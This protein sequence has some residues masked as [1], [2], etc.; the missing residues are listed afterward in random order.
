MKISYFIKEKKGDQKETSKPHQHRK[1]LKNADS[2]KPDKK[3]AHHKLALKHDVFSS[4]T[5]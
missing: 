5:V 4:R 1:K 2:T 3:L